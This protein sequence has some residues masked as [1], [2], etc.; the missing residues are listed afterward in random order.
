MY[1]YT[2][3]FWFTNYILDLIIHLESVI[4]SIQLVIKLIT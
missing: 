1:V 3:Y 2:I 4:I